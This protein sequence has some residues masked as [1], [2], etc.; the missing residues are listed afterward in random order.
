M[1]DKNKETAKFVMDH[2]GGQSNVNSLVHCATRLRFQLKDESIVDEEALKNNPNI[3]TAQAKGGQYQVVIGNN[4]AK[5]YAEIINNTDVAAGGTT[6]ADPAETATDNKLEKKQKNPISVVFEYI[7]GTFSPLIPAL[8][9][10][11]MVKALL[12][13]LEL[14]PAWDAT[15]TTGSVLQAASNGLF[16]FFPIFVA[17]S[18]GKYFKVNPWVAGV[19]GASLLDPNFTGLAEAGGNLNFMGIPLLISDY[20]QTVFPML[21]AIAIYAPLERF[22]KKYIP[23]TIQLFAVPMIS[24]LVMVP[25]TALAFGPFSQFFSGLIADGLL[26]L[27]DLSSLLTGMVMA[28]AWPFLV[29]LGV[30]WGITPISL[31]NLTRGGD[32]LNAMAA[33]ATFAQMGIAFGVFLRYRKNKNLSSLSLSATI[34]GILAGVTEPILYG[35]ILRYKRVIPILVVSSAV[36]GGILG[37]LGTQMTSYAFNS[38]LTIPAYAPIP[39]YV[40]G[41][42]AA[43]ITGTVLT[44]I[45]G[46]GDDVDGDAKEDNVP[47]KPTPVATETQAVSDEALIKPLKGTSLPLDQVDDPVFSSGAMGQGVAVEPSEG[48]LVAPADGEIILLADTKHAVGLKTVQ[49]AE[50]L[51]HVGLDTVELEGKPFNAKVAVG[52]QVKQGDTL[53]EIDL[54]AIKAAGKATTTPVIVTNVGDYTEV[55][56]HNDAE[57]GQ[58]LIQ[59]TK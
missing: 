2:I 10:A 11:G 15:S 38:V 26:W 25:L 57:D 17:I 16:Y 24:I 33:G 48:L 45:F 35:I 6:D 54:A 50:I 53:L 40:I 19:I 51:M 22:L 34:S 9:G 56:V 8:A 14:F 27:L 55:K 39:Q 18:A 30:H 49:G 13:I 4:V 31:D 29:I 23:D 46:L 52:D 12:A 3:L 32:P 5:V 58:T 37:A 41:I 44:F 59:L 1:A 7:S 47:S 28:A 20:S 21:V 36:G 42:S 43:F